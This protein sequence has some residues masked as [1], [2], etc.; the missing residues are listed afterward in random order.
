MPALAPA[1]SCQTDTYIR[2]MKDQVT[3]LEE[4]V[5]RSK[6]KRELLYEPAIQYVCDQLTD[7]TDAIVHGDMATG[8]GKAAR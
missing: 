6:E 8:T 7:L 5:N 1:P 3:K 2:S 4:F